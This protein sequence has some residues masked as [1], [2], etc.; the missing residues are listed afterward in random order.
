ML[1]Q[2]PFD[3]TFPDRLTT[4]H[5]GFGTASF[6]LAVDAAKHLR[7]GGTVS[8]PTLFALADLTMWLLVATTRGAAAS[9]LAVTTGTS[10]DFLRRPAPGKALVAR[11]EVLKNGKRLVVGRV[12]VFSEG[13]EADG[14]VAHATLTYSTPPQQ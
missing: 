4:L 10:I 6:R 12:Q 14:A 2:V 1:L 3:D 11:G 13:E 5:L 8:G 9:A 7:P